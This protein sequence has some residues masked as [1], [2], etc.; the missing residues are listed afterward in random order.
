[1]EAGDW[2]ALDR[3]LSEEAGRI[4]G[5]HPG[6][7]GGY[8]VPSRRE[9]P[10]LPALP[11][12]PRQSE[13]R[14]G[15]RLPVPT[16]ITPASEPLRLRRHPGGRG[17]P[18]EERALGGRGH[19][20]LHDRH[21]DGPGS[22]ER[23]GRRRHLDHDPAGRSDLPR[24]VRPG[25]PLVRG[26]GPGRDRPLARPDRP[27]GA[28]G[29]PPGGRAR[30]APDRVA[31][32]RAPGGAGQA[33]RRR[34][35]RGPQPPGRHPRHHPALAARARPGRRGLRRPDRRGRSARGDRLA[36]L[37]VLAGRRPGPRPGRPERR[38]GRGRPPGRGPRPRAGDPR[39]GRPRPRSAPGRDGPAGLG[40]G[41]PQPDDQR[42]PGHAARRRA[43]AGDPPRPGTRHRRGERG[44]Q[45]AGP[46]G[47]GPGAPV[48]AVL[49]DQGRGNRAGPGDRPRDRPGP[50][51]RAPCR[52]P[53]R[54]RRR[55]HPDTPRRR[56][57][58]P[59][60]ERR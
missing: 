49:H 36:A 1:M 12:E 6:I 37:A 48:R 44:R 45:R 16:S 42:L 41:L 20:P 9:Q 35:P 22:R 56:V 58:A 51:G 11:N 38:G 25:L 27:P 5:R 29:P 31:A 13:A 17:L 28:D 23:P 7:E 47:R 30:P 10:F 15:A 4:R 26:P 33:P 18:E 57:A 53:P 54:R 40:A 32:E 39:R 19:P 43:P 46:V 3:R 34:R 24:P 60:G 14:E 52:E 59:R 55:L 50:P 2:S 8:Y 21:P